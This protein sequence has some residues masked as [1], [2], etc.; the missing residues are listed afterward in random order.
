MRASPNP[1]L[2]TQGF[3]LAVL[4]TKTYRLLL[5]SN[6]IHSSGVEINQYLYEDSQSTIQDV[7]KSLSVLSINDLESNRDI[8]KFTLSSPCLWASFHPLTPLLV[9][10]VKNGNFIKSHAQGSRRIIVAVQVGA[11]KI[12]VEAMEALTKKETE[13]ETQER[14]RLMVF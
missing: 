12:Y 8:C 11:V 3:Q 10:L 9:V 7:L 5:F 6:Q 2:Q 4:S 1:S 13:G 14:S